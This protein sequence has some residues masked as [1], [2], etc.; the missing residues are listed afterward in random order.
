MDEACSEPQPGARLYIQAG[1][2]TPGQAMSEY[3]LLWGSAIITT[4]GPVAPIQQNKLIG[5][6]AVLRDWGEG[7]LS[8]GL[9]SRHHGMC[10]FKLKILTVGGKPL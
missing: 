5:H 9:N 6:T 1:T 8:I 2:F 7:F 4:K 10:Y 3:E